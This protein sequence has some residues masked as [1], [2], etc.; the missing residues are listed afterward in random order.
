M[1]AQ[2]KRLSTKEVQNFSQTNKGALLDI[3]PMA[4]FNGWKLED[5]QRGGHL[6][7]AKSIPLQWTEYMDWVEALKEKNIKK[8]KP[9]LVYGYAHDNINS[10]AQKLDDLGYKKVYTYTDFLKEWTKDASLPLEKLARYQQLVYPEWVQD[11]IN[12][13]NPN[14]YAGKNHVVCHAHY[15]YYEDYQKGH[16]PGAIALNTNWLESKKTWNR[17]SAQELKER[18]KS[19]GI[20]HDSTVVVYGR[21]S[22]PVFD[23]EDFPG[24]SAGHLGAI[25][26]AAILLYAGVKDV[27]ILDGGLT[28]WERAGYK[29]ETKEEKPIPVDSFGAEIPGNPQFMIDTA[30]AKTY[31]KSD[32]SDLVSIR[33]WEEFIGNQSGYHYIEKKGRIPGAVFGN[34]GSDAYHMENYRNFDHTMRQDDEVAEKWIEGGLTPDKKLAFY[35]GTGWRGSEAFFNAYLMGWPNVAVYDGGW[36]EWSN[37]PK[38]PIESGLPE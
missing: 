29:L 23:E 5:E 33:S 3:R 25:R 24:K 8:N 1:S 38:N 18:L 26:C 35:C 7:K 11:L 19:L 10:M 22:A 9:V 21:F 27:K 34:C 36:F 14:H 15:G 31:L 30:E 32:E 4:A 2:F 13:K 16:I 17:R 37:D 6:P 28:S 20:R 12:G